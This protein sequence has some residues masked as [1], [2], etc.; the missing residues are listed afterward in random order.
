MSQGMGGDVGASLGE[1]VGASRAEEVEALRTVML[2]LLADTF[3]L[4]PEEAMW[5]GYHLGEVLAPLASATP[6]SLPLAVVRELRTGDLAARLNRV[7]VEGPGIPPA[8]DPQ[9]LVAKTS[10]WTA[11]LMNMVTACYEVR[12][13]VESSMRGRLDGLLRELGI[14]VAGR[15]RPA[16]YLPNDLRS[17]LSA[18]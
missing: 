1:G 14:G 18:G 7:E 13:M 15:P 2:W 17:R 16:R 6:L 8:E 4:L 12:P 11:V 9:V 5:A 3:A 10:D